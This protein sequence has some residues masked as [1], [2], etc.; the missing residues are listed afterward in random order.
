M[1]PFFLLLSLS[2]SYGTANVPDS[3]S[4]SSTLLRSNLVEFS[5]VDILLFSRAYLYLAFES[6]GPFARF[7]NCTIA[8]LRCTPCAR[9]REGEKGKDI[10]PRSRFVMGVSPYILG[11]VDS[12]R[13]RRTLTP[14]AVESGR[15]RRRVKDSLSP[16]GGPTFDL[17]RPLSIFCNLLLRILN[18]RIASDTR[19]AEVSVVVVRRNAAATAT[20][21]RH[22]EQH[23]QQQFLLPTSPWGDAALIFPRIFSF[24][25][26]RC[27]PSASLSFS[28]SLS[29]RIILSASLTPVLSPR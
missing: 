13:M 10:L 2:R 29:R 28:P 6:S 26:L 14:C 23:H 4:F 3:T 25:P 16:L 7:A 22:Q 11:S 5:W 15:R 20:A 24:R 18:V 21:A 17:Y 9:R 19:A 12:R 1:G 27:S 8:L